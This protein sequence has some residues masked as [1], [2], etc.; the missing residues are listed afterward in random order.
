M[1]LEMSEP[2]LNLSGDHRADIVVVGGGVIGLSV[3]YYTASEGASVLLIEKNSIHSGSSYGNAGLIVP[4]RCQPLPAPKV[5]E[6][7]LR[8]LFN[9]SGPFSIHFRPDPEV[10]RWL[11]KFYRSCNEKQF[12]RATGILS[13]LSRESLLLHNDLARLGGALYEYEQSGLL[14]LFVSPSAF[15]EGRENARVMERYGIESRVLGAKEVRDLEPAIAPGVSGA[16]Q[17]YLDGR[18]HPA[19]FLKW[20]EQEVRAKGV[21][22]FPQTEVFE[23]TRGRKRISTLHTTQGDIHGDQIVIAAGAWTPVLARRLNIRLPIQAGKGYSLTFNPPQESPRIPL[24]FEDFHIAATPF[25]KMFRLTGCIELGGLD[26][27]INMKRIKNIKERAD[28]YLPGLRGATPVEIWRGLRPCTPDGLPIVGNVP[29]YENLWVAAGH[30][31]KG[32]SLGPVTGR[33]MKDLLSGKSA[34]ALG[35]ALRVNRF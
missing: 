25:K 22:I 18:I 2:G 14:S 7:G 5:V 28:T 31:T 30:G 11:W 16:V 15:S 24:L 1:A 4:S 33:L 8:H 20:L 6:K 34:G 3:A 23:F 17:Y 21:K 32:M 10:F 13:E 27:E 29:S 26:M 12:F 9:P 19:A 35:H